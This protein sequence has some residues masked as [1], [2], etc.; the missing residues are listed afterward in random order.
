[1]DRKGHGYGL[2]QRKRRA[3]YTTYIHRIF[4]SS[5]S[6]YTLDSSPSDAAADLRAYAAAAD[7][8]SKQRRQRKEAQD[9]QTLRNYQEFQ[10]FRGVQ[11]AQEDV[12]MRHSDVCM[13]HS[14]VWMM[15]SCKIIENL[16]IS[17]EFLGFG[18][19]QGV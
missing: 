9:A 16:R 10:G 18:E 13:L 3:P 19:V 11:A 4:T 8:E 1:M 2:G 17:K 12:R 15:Q 7:L 6:S 14:D 5:S